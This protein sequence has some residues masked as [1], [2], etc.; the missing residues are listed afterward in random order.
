M[1]LCLLSDC[2]EEG[3]IM[4]IDKYQVILFGVVL[5]LDALLHEMHKTDVVLYK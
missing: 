2:E 1:D 5:S 3:C 4:E